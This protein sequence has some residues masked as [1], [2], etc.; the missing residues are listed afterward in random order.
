MRSHDLVFATALAAGLLGWS[1]TLATVAGQL[2]MGDLAAIQAGLVAA[3]FAIA[4]VVTGAGL[5]VGIV[6]TV[7]VQEVTA[8]VE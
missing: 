1:S 6:G 3:G 7:P 2:A 8:D 4:V 5:L